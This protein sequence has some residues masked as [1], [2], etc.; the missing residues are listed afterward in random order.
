MRRVVTKAPRWQ[1]D[2]RPPV[3]IYFANLRKM[4]P[5]FWITEERYRDAL[6]RHP[7]LHG[8]V[9]AVIGWDLEDF[10]ADIK[11]C[12]ALVG[13]RFPTEGLAECAPELRWIH[14]I[15]AGIEHLRPLTWLPDRIILTNNSG[16]HVPKA[17]EFA[18]MAI[19]MLNNRVPLY[20]TNMRKGQWQKSF[21]S[22]VEGKTLTVIGVG[23]IGGE[24]A[25][26][27][28]RMKMRVLG[29]RRSRRPHRYVD[30]MYAPGD[31]PKVLPRTDFLFI[32][33][34]LTDET[35]GLIGRRELDLLG[36]E[37]GVINMGRA[38]IVD[39]EAL[40]EKLN[41]A[42][43]SGAVLDVFDSEPLPP[44]SPLWNIPNLVITP[45]V[46]ADDPE[47]YAVLSL[48]LILDNVRRYLANRQLRNVVDKA[49]GY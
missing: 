2:G 3:R 41:R 31:L 20:V 24:V 30:E 25:R 44:E 42:E 22:L 45:H 11:T 49:R 19:L 38:G 35:S 13:W 29:V 28:K 12:E 48:D 21:T 14:V 17:T 9:E 15:G 10:A 8:R 4:P 23:H 39:Y 1:R 40:G 32:S 27:A 26:R 47:R 18:I 33:A 46:S 43:L 16:V 37:A 34:P 6:V 5:L 7:D 36:P